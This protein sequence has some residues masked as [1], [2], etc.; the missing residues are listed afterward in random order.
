MTDLSAAA[1]ELL[2]TY[3]EAELAELLGE[4][5]QRARNAETKLA[6]LHQN[7]TPAAACETQRERH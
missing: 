5:T 1:H 6:A 4:A 7:E 2:E 3:N